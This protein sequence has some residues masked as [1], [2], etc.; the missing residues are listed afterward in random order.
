MS[1]LD[2]LWKLQ[3]LA[4]TIRDITEHKIALAFWRH[5]Y[6]Y[7]HAKLI[8]NGYDMIT[9]TL[10][11]LKSECVHYNKAQQVIN[12]DC[13][14]CATHDGQERK[15]GHDW[16]SARPA[17]PVWVAVTMPVRQPTHNTLPSDNYT[18]RPNSQ[19]I[20]DKCMITTNRSYM[21]TGNVSIVVPQIT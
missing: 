4:N 11:T 15:A 3:E 10:V 17:P 14:Q 18:K 7:L 21:K 16:H 12:E 5:C 13:E 8:Q 2:F 6:P 20:K 1:I 9:I 19:V